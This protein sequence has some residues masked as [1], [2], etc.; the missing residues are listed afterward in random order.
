MN[1]RGKCHAVDDKTI[2]GQALKLRAGILR[3]STARAVLARGNNF[4]PR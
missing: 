2:A 4:N 3:D 1:R